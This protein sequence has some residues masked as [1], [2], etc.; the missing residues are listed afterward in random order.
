MPRTHPLAVAQATHLIDQMTGESLHAKRILSLTHA[1]V[2]VIHAVS[3]SIHAIGIGLA[4]AAGLHPK[5]AIKQVDRLLSNTALNVWALFVD[6]VPPVLATQ[7]EIV[8]ALDWTEFAAD[9][10]ATVAVYLVTR[11]GRAMP[12][13]WRTVPTRQLKGQRNECEDSVLLRLHEVVPAGVR[14]TVLADRG[15]GD[16]GLYQLLAS[17]GFDFVI[18]FRGNVTVHSATGEARPATAWVPTNGHIRQLRGATV[19]E[20]AVV[21]VK[22]KGMKQPGCLAVRGAY[23]GTAAVKL[24]GRRFTIEEAFRDTKDARYGLGLSA[25]HIGDPRR[26][27]RLLLICA[28]AMALLTVLGAAG[29]SLGMDRMLKANTVK[30]RTH[31][32]F[33][34]GCYYYAAIPMMPIERLQPLVERFA[35]YVRRQPV[36]LRAFGLD[37][38]PK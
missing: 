25:T 26:R 35:E 23:T 1:V 29:E 19:T 20:D 37:A 27:D 34:Q 6:W 5:H 10:H 36:Y 3:A 28:M 21:C 11:H 30:R 17:F 15:F 9:G 13:V 14:V 8:V 22:A 2:G 7:R 12:L 31:S 33:R 16:Q 4:V 38:A 18:R 24:Y 32:L